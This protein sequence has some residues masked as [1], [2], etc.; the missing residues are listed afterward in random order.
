MNTLAR[1]KRKKTIKKDEIRE[2]IEQLVEIYIPPLYE[3]LYELMNDYTV[4][5]INS[6][7]QAINK[8]FISYGYPVAIIA[9]FRYDSVYIDW[10]RDSERFLRHIGWV[11]QR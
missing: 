11:A 2:H 6:E 4:C 9:T 5:C 10:S 8:I 7:L 1:K 3:Y